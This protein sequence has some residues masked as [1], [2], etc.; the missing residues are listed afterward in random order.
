MALSGKLFDL[1][2]H[3]AVATGPFP[4]PPVQQQ[5]PE[6]IQRLAQKVPLGRIGRPEEIAAAVVFLASDA[7]PYVTGQALVVDG[8]WT[9]W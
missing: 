5:H 6:F 8:G 2:D 9:I 4:A 1:T 3:V 7:A